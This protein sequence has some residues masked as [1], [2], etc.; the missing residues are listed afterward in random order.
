MGYRK[1]LAIAGLAVRTMVRSRL[2][3]T[4]LFLLLVVTAILPFN[5]KGDGTAM[6]QITLLIYYSLGLA[7]IILGAATLWTSCMSIS[8]EIEEKQIQ[9]VTVKPVHLFQVW[10]GKWLGI[11]FVNAALLAVAGLAIY[12]GVQVKIRSSG[13]DTSSSAAIRRDILNSR[14]LFVPERENL[15]KEAHLL[16][17]DMIHRNVISSD[18]AHSEAYAVALKRLRSGRSTVAPGQSRK[19]IIPLKGIS[20][21]NDSKVYLR[22]HLSRYARERCKV[23]GTWIIHGKTPRDT[24]SCKVENYLDGSQILLIPPAALKGQESVSI[25][26]QNGSRDSSNVA[27]FNFERN[28]EIL[29]QKGSFEGNFARTLVIILCHL[30]L[31]A[32]LGLTASAL[33]SFPV[34]TFAV[35]SVFMISVMGHY[36]IIMQQTEP[37][38]QHQGCHDHSYRPSFVERIM[39]PV[40][41]RAD[42]VF[43]PAMQFQPLSQ[44]SDGI[45]ISWVYTLKGVLILMVLYPGILGLTGVYL[46][47]RRE[48]ALPA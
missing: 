44:L 20:I 47:S 21:E 6:G 26:F 16:L 14:Q 2:F 43:A 8:R 42:A 17:E 4:L 12:A 35:V 30:S 33:F 23:A 10:L 7:G 27:V 48:L 22:Y 19:W 15:S 13:V 31:I 34:A 1:I 39:I 11:L 25:T 36:F 32:A 9:M 18:M 3:V 28:L 45:L 40:V 37:G 41:E 24:F 29:V 46:L 38:G 5:I